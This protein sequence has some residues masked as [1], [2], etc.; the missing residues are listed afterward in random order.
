MKAF[1]ENLFSQTRERNQKKANATIKRHET[2]YKLRVYIPGEIVL[3]DVGKKTKVSKKRDM[4]KA[5][6][7]EALTNNY[8]TIE[9]AAGPNIGEQEDINGDLV[10]P[11]Q[12]KNQ[13]MNN[14]VPARKEPRKK[15]LK[16][17]NAAKKAIV[18][19]PSQVLHPIRK[20]LKTNGQSRTGSSKRIIYLP[21]IGV[22]VGREQ[23][24]TPSI[25]VN[26]A[27]RAPN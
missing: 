11:L 5:I 13:V 7:V 22:I 8:Y 23:K 20:I 27:S 14:I 4:V 3:V 10:E 1:A 6:V 2:K 15:G 9:Y 19:P 25:R 18:L 21:W 24:C 26:E 16:S 17:K 12:K